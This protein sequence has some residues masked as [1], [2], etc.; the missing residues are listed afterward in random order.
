MMQPGAFT[1]HIPD[2]VL[3]DLR[4]RLAR[5]QWPEPLPYPGWT[6]GVDL[7]YLRE[8]VGYWATAF[9]WRAQERRLNTFPQFTADIE[10]LT[11]HFVHQRGRGPRSFPLVLTHGWPSS[12]VEL[13]KLVPLLTDPAAHGGD[14]HDSFDVVVP[15]LPGYAFSGHPTQPGVCT[16]RSIAALWARL[17]T[18]A[19]GY[20]RFGAQGQDIG[21]AVTIRLGAD[22][23]DAVAGIHLTGVL[24]FPPQDRPLSAE[25]QAFLARQERWRSGEGAYAHQQ[26]TYPQTLA[27][28]LTDSPAGLA[29]W[30]VD[31]FRAWSDCDGDLERRFS[32]DDLLTHLTIYWATGC[33]N[34]SFLF[35]YESQHD[36][37]PPAGTRV[38]VPVGVALFPKE[39]PVT[40]PR[41]WAEATYNIVRWAEMPRGG[42]FPAAEEPELLAAELRQFFRPLRSA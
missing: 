19:L 36:P 41:E 1:I 40:G 14:V 34:S 15:S 12:F 18:E 10:G 27:C 7:A 38:E 9:D 4:S 39:N 29:A 22:H 28:G 8:L 16:A 6:S 13:L 42:H 5:T 17:M 25:G 21:A 2:E 23:V 31:K 30:I 33:I 35:Y 3:D 11:I 24:A 20:T 37:Q 26:G 32:K